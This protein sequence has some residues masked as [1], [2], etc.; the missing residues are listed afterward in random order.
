MSKDRERPSPGLGPTAWPLPASVSLAPPLRSE[1]LCGRRGAPLEDRVR[2]TMEPDFGFD[3]RGGA[4]SQPGHS[5][6]GM[7]VMSAMSA[8]AGKSDASGESGAANRWIGW[9][10]MAAGVGTGLVLGLWSFDGPVSVP[11]WIGEYGS[12]A[13]RLI[14]LGHIAFIGLAILNILLSRELSRLHLSA[15]AKRTTAI[16]MNIGNVFLPLTLFAAAAIPSLK[17]VMPVPAS[18]VLVTMILAALGSRP[19]RSGSDDS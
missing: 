7:G 9:T 1:S 11:E 13:R 8:D 19:R 5:A 15:V 2:E 17:Y 3:A 18:C 12:T 16:L 4:S 6:P 10:C 14:R